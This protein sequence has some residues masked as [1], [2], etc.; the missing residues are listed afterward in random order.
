MNKKTTDK[1]YFFLQGRGENVELIRKFDWA[2]SPLGS[3]DQWS[4]SLQ[5]TVALILS[6]QFPM[7]LWWGKEHIQF[8]NDAYR[9]SLG[10]SG[11]HPLAIGQRGIDCWP[12]IWDFIYPLMEKVLST[13][14]SVWYEDLL[15]PIY[16]NGN[17]E[18]VY[19][20]FSYS[21]V[22]D[23][24]GKVN[25][26]LVVCTETTDKIKN[27]KKLEESKDELEFAIDATELGTWDLNPITGKFSSNA[28][29]KEWFGLSPEMDIELNMATDVIAPKD[30]QRV[31]D[32][33]EKALKYEYGGLYDVEYTIIHPLTKTERHVHAKGK[34]WFNEENTTYRF[35]GTLQDI[36]EQ[37][38]AEQAVSEARQLTD[39]S[40]RSVGL[41]LF[42]V[43]FIN[44]KIEYTPE[45]AAILTGKKDKKDISR[46]SFVQHIHPDDKH[47]REEAVK[48]GIETGE[49]YYTPRVI[50]DDGS[51][52]RVAIMG[53]RILDQYGNPT[54]FSGTARDLTL[55]ESQKMALEEAELRYSKSKRDSEALFR[56]VTDSSPTGLWLSDKKGGLTYLNKKLVDWTGLPYE[57]LLGSGWADAI[58]EEDRERA[59]L[60]FS[61]AV[62]TKT[63]Y[64]VLF[65]LRKFDDSVV[66]C[67]ASGDPY[68]DENGN[69]KGYAG[70]CMD[71]EE[72]I[73]GRKALVESE[74]LF[75][76]I[77]EQAPVATCLFVGKDMVVEVAN[78]IMIEYWGKD[79]SVI[80]KPLAEAVPELIGQPFLG[81]LDEV[82]TTGNPYTDKAACVIL[83]L[84]GVIGEYYFDFTYKPLRN[85][86]GAIYG[87]MNMSIDVTK[88]VLAQQQIEFH[89]KQLLAS[90]EESPVAIALLTGEDMT[91]Q[92]ANPFY[93]ILVGRHP[94]EIVGKPLL[95]ALPEIKG[96]GFDDLIKEVMAT[97]VPFIAKEVSVNIM[98]NNRLE[99]IYV[100]LTYQPRRDAKDNIIGV[101]VVAI[102]VTEQ[103][104]TRQD[105]EISEA[106]FRS[107]IEDAPIGMALFRGKDM[108]IEV[109]NDILIGFLN[110]DKSIIGKPFSQ[111][112]PELESQGF[113]EIMDTVFTTGISY[114]D[115]DVR[116]DLEWNGIL[117]SRYFNYVYT[118]LFDNTEK[119]Y[120]IM[121]TA[122]EVTEQ[123]KARQN[124]EDVQ[125]ALHGAIEL[126]ELATWK[127]D[128]K[129][130]RFSYS[131]RFRKWMGSPVEINSIEGFY[132]IIPEEDRENIK[133][134]IETALNPSFKGVYNTEHPVVNQTTGQIRIVHFSAQVSYDALGN[135]ES[136]SGMAQNV[137]KERKLKQELEFKVKERTTELQAANHTL[138][139]NNQ[140]L[141][142]FAYIAS[143]DLQEPIRKISVFMQMLESSLESISPKSQVYIDK[144]TTS[145]GRM[146]TLIRDV[147]GFSQL[148]N[149]VYVFEKVDLNQIATEIIVEFELTI[150]QKNA[151]ITTFDL[152]TI[153]AIP[154]QMSQ[155][156]GN[157][158]SNSLKYSR[159]EISPEITI[160]GS[161]LKEEEKQHYNVNP[162]TAYYKIEFKDNG[163]GFNQQY[164]DKIFN[165]FQRLHAKT[166]YAGTG[167]GLA[168]CRKIVQ[169]HYGDI[170]ASSTVDVGSTF[171]VILPKCH[172]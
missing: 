172:K 169:N 93:G 69:F 129:T 166:D 140:E 133:N 37:K 114:E 2:S 158:I 7:F 82:F 61:N 96:Q 48:A 86:D 138:E 44:N 75:R 131:K 67:R 116:V 107:L 101:L 27:L 24:D 29:L 51:V 102:D 74:N 3:P 23:D 83:E 171:T 134:A 66:W 72:I 127:L 79:Q 161:V 89:Q 143:H 126:A 46:K 160:T 94:Q 71:V 42:R 20:T 88:Q 32:A 77:I 139:I 130:G 149:D 9:P 63:H 57:K 56:N 99:T 17:M 113:F 14:E 106:K 68:N 148:S 157:M 109:A 11:K 5:N 156:F 65:R 163:I 43:D 146:S 13:G 136:L 145:A 1:D 105:I 151:V 170:Q 62:N 144:I 73:T 110:K 104:L 95:E 100:D 39:L 91:F 18:D 84:D 59:I 124:L 19:W 70:Y 164:A 132:T 45:F 152:P 120:A 121:L 64:D 58:I 53:A 137:T 135:P 119:V 15:L 31:L 16:R 92:M 6:S 153:D 36:T 123:V 35:N 12:E 4:K 111:V 8:Y 155:L 33:I 80:G 108:V 87:I 112:V 85:A 142:Q 150:E 49:F 115:Y 54:M 50:W 103:V 81:I 41:G 159:P 128:K 22:W 76:S 26:V 10:N 28:R 60:A 40:I 118:P 38:K 162:E 78:H 167:I 21:A 125:I 141:Q 147:L 122:F 98:R 25:G 52:H 30:R 117:N 34:A 97:G 165:I 168:M 55:Q 47:L 90:F 154:L